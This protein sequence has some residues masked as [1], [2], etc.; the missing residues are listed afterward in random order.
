MSNP[1]EE[2]SRRNIYQVA[3]KLDLIEIGVKAQMYFLF[4]YLLILVFVSLHV[5]FQEQNSHHTG[6]WE[7]GI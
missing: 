1:A 6:P 3:F 2:F 7:K 5:S 4:I